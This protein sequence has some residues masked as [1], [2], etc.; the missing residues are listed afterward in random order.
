MVSRVIISTK[1]KRVSRVI[2]SMYKG[3]KRRFK[4]FKYFR[5][6]KNIYKSLF[7]TTI[8]LLKYYLNAQYDII[9]I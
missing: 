4:G 2:M 9:N 1:K 3:F 8:Q 7:V 6:Y 5:V